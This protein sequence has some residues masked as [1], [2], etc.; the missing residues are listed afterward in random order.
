VSSDGS[1]VPAPIDVVTFEEV[2]LSIVIA[3]GA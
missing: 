1:V 2:K 3:G